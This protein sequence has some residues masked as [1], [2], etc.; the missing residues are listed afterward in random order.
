MRIARYRDDGTALSNRKVI[1]DGIPA[2]RFHAGCRLRVGPDGKLYATTGDATERAL[3]QRMDSLAGKT[4]RLEPDGGIPA[5]NPFPG[6]P[7]FS[8]GHRNAQGLDWHSPS[9]LQFQTEHGPSGFDGPGG[10]D[11][12]NLVEKGR[13]YGWPVIQHRQSRSGFVSPLLEWT[14]AIAPSGASFIR[15]DGL[16]SLRNDFLFACL[17]GERLIRVRLDP[18]DPRRVASFE[19]LFEGV[20][21][22]LRE[23]MPGPDGAIYFTTSNRDG[24]GGPAPDDDRI[25]RLTEIRP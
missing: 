18:K 13:N 20:F 5:D 2:A 11:E 3:A 4:L 19:D 17:Q 8:L 16:P 22:R 6:S 1:L 15:G 25:L 12:V 14:P 9:G 10:G 24:R 23:V 7:I 21:G